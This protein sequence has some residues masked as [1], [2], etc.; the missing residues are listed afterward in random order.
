MVCAAAGVVDP[1]RDPSIGD[2]FMGT[3][4]LSVHAA[5]SRQD[6]DGAVAPPGAGAELPGGTLAGDVG[7]CFAFLLQRTEETPQVVQGDSGEDQS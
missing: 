3:A 6:V 2:G 4:E 1:V 5:L 7:T